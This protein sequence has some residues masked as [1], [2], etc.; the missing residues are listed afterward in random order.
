MICSLNGKQPF[1]NTRKNEEQRKLCGLRY[2]TKKAGL[3]MVKNASA[4]KSLCKKGWEMQR[5]FY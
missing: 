2:K 5:A 3:F 1:K 4:L